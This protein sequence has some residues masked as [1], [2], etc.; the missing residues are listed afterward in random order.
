MFGF[1]IPEL[2]IILVVIVV[3]A[4]PAKLPQLGAALGETLR[5]FRKGASEEPRV[6][7][8]K[9]DEGKKQ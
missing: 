5:S 7:N 6:I 4:G 9:D 3:I 2:L 1:G 8:P